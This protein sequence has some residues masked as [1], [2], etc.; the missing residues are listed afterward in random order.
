MWRRF[1]VIGFNCLTEEDEILKT[2][3]ISARYCHPKKTQIQ[4]FQRIESS[5]HKKKRE[6]SDE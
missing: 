5:A 3:L 1:F 4:K 2:G 6:T